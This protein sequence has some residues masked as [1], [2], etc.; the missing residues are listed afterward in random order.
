MRHPE[1]LDIESVA[2]RG[3]G[4]R[5]GAEIAGKMHAQRQYAAQLEEPQGGVV[6][7]LIAAAFRRID[8]E[9]H[10]AARIP[11]GKARAPV[12]NAGPV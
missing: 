5:D 12:E 6:L 8:N 2:V 1:K 9:V 7:V 4:A 3:G 10:E 11:R